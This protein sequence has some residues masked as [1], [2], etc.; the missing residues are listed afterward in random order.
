MRAAAH[1]PGGTAEATLFEHLR[2][3]GPEVAGAASVLAVVAVLHREARRDERTRSGSPAP[4][5]G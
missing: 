1:A 4:G 3:P 2:R 5:V